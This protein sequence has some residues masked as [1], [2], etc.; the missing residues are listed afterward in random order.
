MIPGHCIKWP[1][2]SDG[3]EVGG[4]RKEVRNNIDVGGVDM[5]IHQSV[6]RITMN[7]DAYREK[8]D[9]EFAFCHIPLAL[10]LE[11]LYCTR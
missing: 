9:R 5:S 7:M 3:V 6:G 2:R 8:R 11:Y 10:S 1:F 4:T